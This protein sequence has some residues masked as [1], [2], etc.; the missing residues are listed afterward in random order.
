MYAFCI[1]P[2]E[3]QPSGALNF[4]RV[5][6]SQLQITLRDDIT[7]TGKLFVYAINY[8]VLRVLSGMGGL[9]FSN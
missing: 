9:A 2:E 7:G 1:S 6:T 8:N 4:S 5:D 3:H